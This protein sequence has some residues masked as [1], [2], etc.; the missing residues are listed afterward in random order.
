[1]P[2]I[3]SSAKTMPLKKLCF[4]YHAAFSVAFEEGGYFYEDGDYVEEKTLVLTLID[5]ERDTIQKI[6]KDFCSMF[7]QESI[8]VTEDNVKGYYIM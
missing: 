4:I 8:L 3:G 5:A 6:A 7:H 2:R 1:M